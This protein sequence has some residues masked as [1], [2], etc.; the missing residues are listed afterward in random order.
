MG[1]VGLYTLC[2]ILIDKRL[3]AITS[4]VKTISHFCWCKAL[5]MVS[6]DSLI[7]SVVTN[8]DL[9]RLHGGGGVWSDGEDRGTGGLLHKEGSVVFLLLRQ[10]TY[11]HD[12][13]NMVTCIQDIYSSVI[14][15]TTPMWARD[16]LKP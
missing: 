3:V 5:T 16:C 14:L 15:F 9:P 6:C 7:K 2:Y 1:V 11:A 12:H 13:Y 10:P 4:L 8:D